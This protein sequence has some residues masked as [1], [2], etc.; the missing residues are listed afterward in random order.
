MV[1]DVQGLA[2]EKE[3]PEGT[4][5]LDADSIANEFYTEN[6]DSLGQI[7]IEQGKTF[8]FET[9]TVRDLGVGEKLA[10][11]AGSA[12]AEVM[13]FFEALGVEDGTKAQRILDARQNGA[14]EIYENLDKQSFGAEDIGELAAFAGGSYALGV[15]SLPAAK[16]LLAKPGAAVVAK[17]GGAAGLGGEA[18]MSFVTTA[19]GGPMGAA[20]ARLLGLAQKTKKGKAILNSLEGVNPASAKKLGEALVKEGR[21]VEKMA[22]SVPFKAGA[23]ERV[24]AAQVNAAREM[25]ANAVKRPR[26]T[27]NTG[28]TATPSG[29]ARA[30]QEASRVKAQLARMNAV[31]KS[32]KAKKTADRKAQADLVRK[33]NKQ[34]GKRKGT[35]E[36]DK[37]ETMKDVLRSEQASRTN[38]L[39]RMEQEALQAEQ[40]FARMGQRSGLSDFL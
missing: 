26:Q 13:S 28:P 22:E 1:V 15:A 3:F 33:A 23:N 25:R 16:A 37:F 2:I 12:V 36:A 32:S 40:A 6:P 34:K 9:G 21:K 38:K 24:R 7:A 4:S 31:N 29:A 18:L 19:I 27:G 14:N 5:Q 17:M 30:S 10:I 8:D 20:G 11:G 39:V 35:G